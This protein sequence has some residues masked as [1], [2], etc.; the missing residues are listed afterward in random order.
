MNLTSKPGIRDDDQRALSARKDI[1]DVV[2][3]VSLTEA[4]D[5]LRR[6]TLRRH[7]RRAFPW[8]C[9]VD[10]AVRPPVRPYALHESPRRAAR[11]G[12]HVDLCASYLECHPRTVGRH[13]HAPLPRC[14]GDR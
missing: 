5:G 7:A 12:K 11:K 3:C 6:P 9:H 13:G 14:T 1:G 2:P 8:D 4:R 10:V